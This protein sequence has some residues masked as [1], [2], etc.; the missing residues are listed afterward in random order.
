MSEKKKYK[1][2]SKEDALGRLQQYCAYQDR[3]HQEVR[4][5]LIEI[6]CYSDDLE[7]VMCDLIA[8]NFLNEERFARS[9]VRGKF[10]LKKW[11]KVKI[12]KELKLRNIS[13]YCL[14]KAFE[15]INEEDYQST[16]YELL[17]KKARLVKAKNQYDKN[18]KLANYMI[19][20]GY[21][22]GLIWEI[23]KNEEF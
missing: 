21:E 18:N 22:V 20:K 3:C 14:R 4:T 17:N 12:R 8:E 6:G 5:K 19:Q 7:E 13:A 9:Y 1:Y 10:N 16:I 23:L 2:I 15:E 11:G